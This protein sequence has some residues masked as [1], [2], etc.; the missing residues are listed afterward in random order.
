MLIAATQGHQGVF[1]V[2]VGLH[3]V[4]ALV[5]FGS[6]AI[7]GVYG[8][9]ARRSDE[10][11]LS[12][13]TARYFRSRGWTELLILGVP[14]FGAAAIGFRPEGADFGG[15]WVIGGFVAWALAAAL[16]LGVVRPAESRIRSGGEPA[17]RSG[18]GGRLMWAAAGCDVLFVIALALMIT[19][20]A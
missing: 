18:S 12:E 7:S 11:G 14:V 16:L 5:G 4:S 3:V 9:A 20:P 6:V 8:A 10:S 1:D 15:L 17:D 13:E 19:Q 2:L